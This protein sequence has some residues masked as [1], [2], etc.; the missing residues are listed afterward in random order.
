[1]SMLLPLILII[2]VLSSLAE[3]HKYNP[4]RSNPGYFHAVILRDMRCMAAF[5]HPAA[6]IFAVFVSAVPAGCTASQ[7]LLCRD[8]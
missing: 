7:R 6:Q 5:L 4:A 3:K 1:M 2:S 8:P